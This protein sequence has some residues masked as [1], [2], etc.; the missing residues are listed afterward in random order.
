MARR[1]AQQLYD[2]SRR[3]VQGSWHSEAVLIH[4]TQAAL[5]SFPTV[6]NSDFQIPICSLGIVLRNKFPRLIDTA[7]HDLRPRI[8]LFADLRNQ[9][10]ACSGL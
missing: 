4:L 1:P 9:K 5:D 2:T 6:A 10:T 7:Q 8:I 3:P